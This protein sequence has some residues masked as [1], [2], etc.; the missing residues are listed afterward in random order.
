MKQR[1]EFFFFVFALFRITSLQISILPPPT[2][3]MEDANFILIPDVKFVLSDLPD[4]WG[5]CKDL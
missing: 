2:G 3:T 1:L 4:S 5:M